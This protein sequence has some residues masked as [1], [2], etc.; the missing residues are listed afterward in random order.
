MWYIIKKITT[1]T[2]VLHQAQNLKKNIFDPT[3]I[4]FTELKGDTLKFGILLIAGVFYFIYFNFKFKFCG[5]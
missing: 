1:V 3:S 2:N 5:N 4:E